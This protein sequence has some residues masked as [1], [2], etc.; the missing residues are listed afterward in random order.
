MTYGKTYNESYNA[1]NGAPP[2]DFRRPLS[3]PFKSSTPVAIAYD[4]LLEQMRDS[5]VS[6]ELVGRTYA[7]RAGAETS[8]R[9]TKDKFVERGVAK[10]RADMSAR[11]E[12]AQTQPTRWVY[13]ITFAANLPGGALS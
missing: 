13:W 2:A 10:R 7:S 6:S 4:Q 3:Y 12:R 9:N 5:W 11:I 8:A 1:Y